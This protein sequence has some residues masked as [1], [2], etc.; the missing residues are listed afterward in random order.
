MLI[1]DR[2]GRRIL[3]ATV[4]DGPWADQP[5]RVTYVDD[6][7]FMPRVVRIEV[8]NDDQFPWNVEKGHA[9][10]VGTAEAKSR[11]PLN[12]NFLGFVLILIG[13]FAPTTIISSPCQSNGD[14]GSAKTEPSG[15]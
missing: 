4:I 6:G 9:G 15:G 13:A 3:F 2:T 12:V 10:W 14:E 8:L 1:E 5:V 7:G 11:A